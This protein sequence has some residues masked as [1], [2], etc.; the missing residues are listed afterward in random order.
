M[1]PIRHTDYKMIIPKLL[2]VSLFSFY[3]NATTIVAFWTEQRIIIAADSKLTIRKDGQPVSS[4]T[5]CKIH[6]VGDLVVAM[7][8]LY[9]TEEED[10]VAAVKAAI[11]FKPPYY[12]MG[13]IFAAQQALER[14]LKARDERAN[15][16]IYDPNLAVQLIIATMLDGKPR[17]TRIKF[18]P[19]PAMPEEPGFRVSRFA[20]STVQYPENRGYGGQDPN[21]GVEIIGLSGAISEF[22]KR[23]PDQWDGTDEP[24]FAKKLV[25]IE[26]ND[27][28]GSQF[29]GAPISLLTI[30]GKGIHWIEGGACKSEPGAPANH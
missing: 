22:R 17:M 25:E 27:K 19:F 3:L 26:A 8:G 9:W 23:V 6:M 30:D 28:V 2:L 4:Q 10:V 15:T 24:Q 21:H 14:V 20:T 29:V 13:S 16:K 5:V 12:E 18:I 1:G 11:K 7:A